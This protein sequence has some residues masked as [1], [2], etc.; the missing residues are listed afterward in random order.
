MCG[1][2]GLIGAIVSVVY[3]PLAPV[4][5]AMNV[6]QGIASGNLLQA[7]GGAFGLSGLGSAAGVAGDGFGVGDVGWTGAGASAGD[8]T[9]NAFSG[10]LDTGMIDLATVGSATPGMGFSADPS[11]GFSPASSIGDASISLSDAV[12]NLGGYSTSGLAGE[13]YKGAVETAMSGGNVGDFLRQNYGNHDTSG[14]M[15]AVGQ[16]NWKGVGEYIKDTQSF[17]DPMESNLGQLSTAGAGNTGVSATFGSPTSTAFDPSSSTFSGEPGTLQF[18]PS[19]GANADYLGKFSSSPASSTPVSA[20]GMDISGSTG[21]DMFSVAQQPGGG[22]GMKTPTYDWTDKNMFGTSSGTGFN[23]N[24]AVTPI[25]Q[26]N[27][28]NAKPFSFSQPTSMGETV[29]GGLEKLFKRSPMETAIKGVG[30]LDSY[31]SNKRAMGR[32]EEMYSQAMSKS[33]PFAADRAFASQKWQQNIN[34]PDTAWNEYIAGQGGRFLQDAAAK[35][36]KAGRRNMLPTLMSQ[37]KQQFMADYIPRYRDSVNPK[38]FPGGSSTSVATS[39]APALTNL[40]KNQNAP[41]FGF[42]G[43]TV[44]NSKLYSSLFGE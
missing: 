42:L 11:L 17:V 24:E 43:D 32:L 6:A 20:G 29:M 26:V 35:Y 14:I 16:K 1:G 27:L 21:Q 3:P 22:L 18:N 30:A 10:G 8:W 37:A 2:S 13:A 19:E 23:I 36:A 15:E 28:S 9:S 38:Q 40:T 34:D 41:I 39:F 25:G 31:M 5:A 4:V 7:A 33:D 12:S 44:Q